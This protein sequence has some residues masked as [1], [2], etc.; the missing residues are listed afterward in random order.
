F[1]IVSSSGDKNKRAREYSLARLSLAMDPVP[2]LTGWRKINVWSLQ[3]S[4]HSALVT[5]LGEFVQCVWTC[6]MS[7]IALQ[8]IA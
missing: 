6:P 5:L 8:A 1:A 7:P 2:T 3:C 4:V